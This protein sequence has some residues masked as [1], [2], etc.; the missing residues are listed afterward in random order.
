MRGFCGLR[1]FAEMR[2]IV[3]DLRLF[4]FRAVFRYRNNNLTTSMSAKLSLT[5]ALWTGKLAWLIGGYFLYP[6]S[7]NHR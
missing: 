7:T 3:P 5:L 2:L 1:D 6:Y 4:L